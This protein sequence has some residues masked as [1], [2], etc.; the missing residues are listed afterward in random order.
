MFRLIKASSV[1]TQTEPSN[2]TVWSDDVFM[3]R[4]MLPLYYKL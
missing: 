4:N 1:Q 3:R 2:D